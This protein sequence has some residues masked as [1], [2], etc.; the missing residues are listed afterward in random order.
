MACSLRSLDVPMADMGA[1][2]T[3]AP[4]AVAGIAAG[5]AIWRSSARK[6]S[7]FACLS[8]STSSGKPKQEILCPSEE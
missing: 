1:L 8:I 5:S 4:L 2:H 7:R 3:R 6:S